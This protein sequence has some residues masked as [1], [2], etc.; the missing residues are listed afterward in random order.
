MAGRKESDSRK[1]CWVGVDKRAWVGYND[2][3]N[4]RILALGAGTQSSVLLLMC[5]RGQVEPVECALFSDTG[6][7]PKEV[8][9]H[10]NWLENESKTPIIRCSCGKLSE[11]AI[12]YQASHKGVDGRYAS[13]PFYTESGMQPRQCTKYY[14]V[15]PIIRYIRETMFGLKKGE[16]FPKDQ[17]VTQLI[18]MSFEEQDRVKPPHVKWMIN[19]Y[20]LIE[21]LMRRHKVIQ[22]SE[23]WFPNHKFPRSACKQCPYRNDEEWFSLS[24]EEFEETCQ[25]EEKASFLSEAAGGGKVF[26]HRSRKP[27]RLVVLQHGDPLFD[28]VSQN[29][30]G[31]ICGI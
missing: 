5:D 21:K 20:P 15:L 22:L 25:F 7:E 14:K 27:L 4:R 11:D 16:R 8:Y 13:I 28:G 17:T 23:K 26:L 9:E 3:M 10:L 24:Q 29:E 18:G 30:C 19:E 12:I 31:G 6:D 1:Y 2:G